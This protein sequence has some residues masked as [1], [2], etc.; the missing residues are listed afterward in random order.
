VPKVVKR[1]SSQRA[2]GVKI[3]TNLLVFIRVPL[4]YLR[5]EHIFCC[6]SLSV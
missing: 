4:S 1:H 3:I 2:K 6:F 5:G